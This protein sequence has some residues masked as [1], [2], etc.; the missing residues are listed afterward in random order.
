MSIIPKGFGTNNNIVVK[1]FGRQLIIILDDG[2]PDFPGGLILEDLDDLIETKNVI[3]S[4]RDDSIRV[5][6]LYL[7]SNDLEVVL[8]LVEYQKITVCTSREDFD[9]RYTYK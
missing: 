2:L 5:D 6:V 8:E 9:D 7:N 4:G 1:G 3:I